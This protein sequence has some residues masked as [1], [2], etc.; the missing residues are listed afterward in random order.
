MDQNKLDLHKREVFLKMPK[1]IQDNM[2]LL[3]LGGSHAYGTNKETSD[4]DLRGVCLKTQKQLLGLEEFEQYV[5]VET[6]T[7][8]Y[9]FDK[10]VKLCMNCN[11]NVIEM[12]GCK[13]EHYQTLSKEGKLLIDNAHLFLSKRAI[14]SFGGYA[15]A[16]LRRLQN[17]LARDEYGQD[18]KEEH[19]MKTIDSMKY[20]LNSH[21]SQF[22]LDNL[23]IYTDKSNKPELEKETV[24]HINLKHYPLRS[25]VDIHNEM[26]NV[27]KQYDKLG[28][29]ND[30]K[31]EEHLL[32]H[33]MHLVRLYLMLFDILKGNGVRT[34]REEDIPLLMGIRNGKYTYEEIFAFVDVF[35]N[36]MDN[37]AK[38]T[39]LPDQ[40]D[41]KKINE[42]MVEIN[43]SVV[44]REEY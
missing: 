20:H 32:K 44:L 7:T 33:A 12:L 17:A 22:G 36:N 28:K 5:D 23:N 42:L 26:N 2:I 34:Y 29:R 31:D 37:L 21:Y 30:K 41:Y 40:P 11:P 10:F 13:P 38:E 6:D 3:T 19:I 1:K 14:Y 24:I 16:Q 39:M 35:E 8:I 25:F 9:A 27:I 4:I 18:E 15:T 43:K